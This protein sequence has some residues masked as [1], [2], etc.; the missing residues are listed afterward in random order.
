MALLEFEERMAELD[1]ECR[2]RDCRME[3]ERL[4]KEKN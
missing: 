1:F 3:M 4:Q 2:E